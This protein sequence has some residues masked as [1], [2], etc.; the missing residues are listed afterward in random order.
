[1][2]FVKITEL[3]ENKGFLLTEKSGKIVTENWGILPV[4]N[5]GETYETKEK[6]D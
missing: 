6:T 4:K 2:S 1:M 5:K 3:T